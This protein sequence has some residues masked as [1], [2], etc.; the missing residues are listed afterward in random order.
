[1]FSNI[2]EYDEAEW[3]RLQAWLDWV[4]VDFKQKVADGRSMSLEQVEEVARGRIWS[5]ERA[6]TLGLV[7]ELGGLHTALQLAK[8]EAEFDEDRDV[9]VEVFPR[10]KAWWQELLEDPPSSSEDHG[11]AAASE[12]ATGLERWRPI[13][14]RMSAM[15]LGAQDAGVLTM[16]PMEIS[17]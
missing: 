11:R 4:Y 17:P 14:A 8:R 3:A 10:P 6:Q 7:D 5:G 1:M 2:H 9:A 12:I 15:G 16:T 13:A